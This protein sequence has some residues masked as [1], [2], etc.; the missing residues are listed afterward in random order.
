MAKSKKAKSPTH[1]SSQHLTLSPFP[2]PNRQ[3][4][5]KELIPS[6]LT[7]KGLQ[8]AWNLRTY[9]AKGKRKPSKCLSN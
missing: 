1:L 7:F 3:Q 6:E 9:H 4:A 8:L 2:T 5:E